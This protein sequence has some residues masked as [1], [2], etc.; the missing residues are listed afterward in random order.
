SRRRPGA[1]HPLAHRRQTL[2]PHLFLFRQLN[3]R[4]RNTF[5]NRSATRK[6]TGAVG[7]V[8]LL[9]GVT[10]VAFPP[11]P[12]HTLFGLVRNQWGDPINVAGA[13]VFLE[14]ANGPGVTT[15]ISPGLEPGV[16]Y[17]L[18][19]PMDSAIAPDLY[20]PAAL[21]PL[22]PFRLR[23]KIGDTVYLPIEMAI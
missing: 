18:L 14:T 6:L 1:T 10:A 8:C 20:T 11:A 4:T 12:H 15:T 23:V 13:Q 21:K 7:L 9:I 3:S 16:N 2:L 22:V 19:L 5:M 17:R